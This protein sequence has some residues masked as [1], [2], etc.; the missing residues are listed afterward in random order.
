MPGTWITAAQDSPIWALISTY[1]V[2]LP[3]HPEYRTLPMVWYIP[4]LSPLV[5]E[6][7]AA[8]LDGENHKVLLTAVSQMRIPLEYLA[9]LLFNSK[10]TSF[11][12][13]TSNVPS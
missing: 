5:D 12:G 9:K 3:L 11:F 10:P 6:V 8:G 2:A 7:A 4:P 13:N 1:E